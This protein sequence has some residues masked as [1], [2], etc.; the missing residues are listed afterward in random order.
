MDNRFGFSPR[1]LELAAAAERTA[2]ERFAQIDLTTEYNQ[3]KV[4]AAF[5]DNNVSEACFGASTGYGYGDRGR[6]AL[7]IW[8]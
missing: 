7:R 1:V 4:L 6:G 5:I 3:Q 8:A 2:A